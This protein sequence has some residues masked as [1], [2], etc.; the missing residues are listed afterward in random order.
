MVDTRKMGAT[1]ID[2]KKTDKHLYQPGTTPELVD[3]PTM[4]FLAVDG[5]GDPNTSPAYTD[6]IEALY[7]ISYGIK[8]AHKQTLEYVVPPLEGLWDHPDTDITDKTRFVFTAM[9]R[10]PEF[11]TQDILDAAKTSVARKKP[12][13]SLA[14]LRLMPLTESLCVQ[15]MHTGPYD[16]EPETIAAM[17]TFARDTG[18]VEDLGKARRH[19]EIYLSDPRRTAPQ[20][21]KTVIRHPVKPE[22]TADRVP[23]V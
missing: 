14:G 3:V 17:R 10:Q 11:V 16:T 20:K 23:L 6:A 22:Q 8:M 15:A 19:H 4:L 5:T 7:A 12:G 18:Y 1:M 9:I 13:L 21:L 2:F